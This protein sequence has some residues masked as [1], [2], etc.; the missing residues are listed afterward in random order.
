MAFNKSGSCKLHWQVGIVVGS[1][2]GSFPNISSWHLARV[3]LWPTFNQHDRLESEI[4][5]FSPGLACCPDLETMC[6]IPGWRFLRTENLALDTDPELMGCLPPLLYLN[7]VEINL[8]WV[9][10]RLL[11]S[12]WNSGSTIII[13]STPPNS[14]QV[15]PPRQMFL[16]KKSFEELC[17]KKFLAKYF[18]DSCLQ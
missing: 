3:I 14:S 17:R 5:N 15:D 12:S 18:Q 9:G 1:V 6:A 13:Q 10:K 8:T 4:C 2:L 11:V 7:L 16:N